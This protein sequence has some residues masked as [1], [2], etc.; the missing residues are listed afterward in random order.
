MEGKR[1]TF[2]QNPPRQRRHC[3]RGALAPDASHQQASISKELGPKV[4]SIQNEEPQ[5]IKRGFRGSTDNTASCLFEIELN[6]IFRH[7]LHSL[8]SKVPDLTSHGKHVHARH[9]LADRVSCTYAPYPP[10]RKTTTGSPLP[11]KSESLHYV[12]TNTARISPE[13]DFV[14]PSCGRSCDLENGQRLTTSCTR[15]VPLA[16]QKPIQIYGDFLN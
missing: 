6:L 4:I 15:R 14:Q 12:K 13:R 11:E 16:T 7:T 3:S 9:P 2:L 5:I 10:Q 8:Y 1:G